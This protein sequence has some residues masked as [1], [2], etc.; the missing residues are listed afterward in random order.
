MTGEWRIVIGP[1]LYIYMYNSGQTK[2]KGC[3][4]A[5][6]KNSNFTRCTARL[7]TCEHTEAYKVEFL[8]M[9]AVPSKTIKHAI[10][11][12]SQLI[13]TKQD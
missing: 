1:T 7:N 8:A 10:L 11:K 9:P 2:N 3:L 12:G 4:A 6:A 13:A 5:P